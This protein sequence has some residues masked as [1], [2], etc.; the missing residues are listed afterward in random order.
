MRVDQKAFHTALRDP[1]APIPEGLIDDANSP[2]GRRFDVYRNNVTTS[3]MDALAD[4]FPVIKKLLGETNFRNLAREYQAAHPPRSPLMT[5]FGAEFPAFMRGHQGL[6]TLPYLG[7]V[8]DLELALRHSYHAADSQPIDVG[9]FAALDEAALLS[10]TFEF[11]P[12]MRFIHSDW[13][14]FGIWQFNTVENAPK[15]VAV[16]QSVLIVRQEFD[17]QP[18]E[19]TNADVALLKSLAN[20]ETLE[21]ALAAAQSVDNT[22]DF[23]AILQK[24]LAGNAITRLETGDTK[25]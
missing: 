21:T 2:A 6:S 1:L 9:I 19:I 13:P 16:S 23:G 8:A 5:H 15:P 17:P 14:V 25:S 18:W 22:H 4:G 3:L 11:A 12:S 24:L 10:L 20:G 7:D